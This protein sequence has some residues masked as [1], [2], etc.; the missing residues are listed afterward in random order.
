MRL[1]PITRSLAFRLFFLI[2][3]IQTV[4]LLV[5]TYAVIEFQQSLFMNHMMDDAV[6]ISDLIARS[7]RYSMML[8][9]KEDV[10]EIISSVGSEPGIRGIRIYNKQGEVIFATQPEDIHTTVDMKAEACIVCHE[11]LSNPPFQTA[12]RHR[13]MGGEGTAERQLGLITPIRNEPACAGAP[14]HAHPS[15]KTILGV[16]DVKMSLAEVDQELASSQAT[17]LTLSAGAVVLVG[18]VAGAFLWLF[19]RRPVRRLTEGMELVASGHLEHRLDVKGKDELGMLARTFNAMAADL[20]RARQEIT[21]WSRTLEVKVR[22][23]TADLERAHRQ[24]VQV[25]KMA[26]LGNL[27]SSVAHELNNP[28]EG[29]L[30]YAKVIK[31]RLGKTS[32]DPSQLQNYEEELTL[33][34]DEARRCGAIVKN[35]LVFS[36]KREMTL[37]EARFCDILNRSVMLVQHHAQMRDVRIET[38]CSQDLAIECDPDHLQ[39]VLVALMVNA[40]EAMSPGKDRSGGGLLRV[41]AELD[42]RT[43]AVVIRVADNGV[44]MSDDV[45][46]HIFEPFFTTKSEGKGVGLGLAIVY[47]IVERHS[48]TITVDSRTGEGTVFTIRVPLRQ[49]SH[50]STGPRATEPDNEAK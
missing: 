18:L 20:Q 5:F 13:I 42:V 44:G 30:T 33:I 36:R 35:L 21:D 9:R 1:R 46:A 7:T 11:D 49:P 17:L 48:G 25:E 8:N 32:L 24:M 47:G 50:P 6:Q 38:Q 26:S 23:K 37:K 3:S 43:D 4:V 31:K 19:V 27:A 12:E 10:H 40:V 2:A 29:I 45:K 41:S 15:E 14:C 16:L 28:L 39:Q 34:A 22:E